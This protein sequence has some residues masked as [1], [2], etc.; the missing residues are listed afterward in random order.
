ME[1]KRCQSLTPLEK[2]FGSAQGSRRKDHKAILT[3]WDKI[4]QMTPMKSK[5][6]VIKL[7][8]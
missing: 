2:R 4:L 5:R 6:G 1:K 3:S 7:I 8:W